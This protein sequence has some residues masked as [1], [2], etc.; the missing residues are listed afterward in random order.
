MCLLLEP[1]MKSDQYRVGDRIFPQRDIANPETVNESLLSS[2]C[3]IFPQLNKEEGDGCQLDGTC[4]LCL[5]VP[6][7]ALTSCLPFPH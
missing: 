6:S 2:L 5:G 3:L 7:L 1:E 4:A